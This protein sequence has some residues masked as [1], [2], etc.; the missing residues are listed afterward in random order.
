MM[1]AAYSIVYADDVKIHLRFID[2]RHHTLIRKTIKE[3]LEYEPLVETKNQKLLGAPEIY[4]AD[5][6]LRCGPANTI[7][8][9]Y[10][11]HLDPEHGLREVAVLAI[12]IKD[13]ERLLIAGEEQ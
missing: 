2:R 7:R 5:W 1:P 6:E 9:F 3:R 4:G 12:G 10:R 13:R 8:V 11:V